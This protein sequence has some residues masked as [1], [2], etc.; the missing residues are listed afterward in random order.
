MWLSAA[1]GMSDIA[2]GLLVQREHW[3]DTLVSLIV[4]QGAIAVVVQ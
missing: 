2:F 1:V 3:L 4:K